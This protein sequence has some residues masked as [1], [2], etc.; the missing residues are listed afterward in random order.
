MTEVLEALLAC[1]DFDGGVSSPH[2]ETMILLDGFG[3]VFSAGVVVVVG[4]FL[5]VLLA[6]ALLAL[7]A[8]NLATACMKADGTASWSIVL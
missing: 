1:A 6:L 4:A 2:W 5:P 3:R 8:C 7:T